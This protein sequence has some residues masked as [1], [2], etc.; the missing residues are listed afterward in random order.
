MVFKGLTK[1][2]GWQAMFVILILKVD[3]MREKTTTTSLAFVVVVSNS[4]TQKIKP[5]WWA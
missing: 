3:G 1:E 4:P 5:R 2:K